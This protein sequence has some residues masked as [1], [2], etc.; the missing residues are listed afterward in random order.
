MELHGIGVE[1]DVNDTWWVSL[2]LGGGGYK[3]R[4]Q[5]MARTPERARVLFESC[6]RSAVSGGVHE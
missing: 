3:Q 6:V 1:H 5:R 2:T 4:R